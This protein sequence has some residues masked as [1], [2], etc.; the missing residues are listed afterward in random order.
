MSNPGDATLDEGEHVPETD[1]EK[2]GGEVRIMERSE[3]KAAGIP[4][5]SAHWHLFVPTIV[6]AVLYTSAWLI[7]A[8]LGHS[9]A[10]IARLF[11]VVMAVGVP[12]LAVHAFL[13]FETIR[14]Q[15]NEGKIQLH[16]GWPRELPIEVSAEM[17]REVQVKRGLSGSVFGGGTLVL[18]VIPDS[19]IVV[20]DLGEPDEAAA[21]IEA[22]VAQHKDPR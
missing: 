14:L 22:L 13:R 21:A 7:L 15:I 2:D 18:D 17:I 6:I 20:A 8:I 5:F 11:V 10:A 1:L 3:A 4:F 19:R 12:L 16:T 9:D